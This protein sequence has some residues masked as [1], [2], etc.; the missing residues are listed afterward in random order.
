MT[1]I[2]I[3]LLIMI[4]TNN[5]NRLAEAEAYCAAQPLARTCL[6]RSRLGTSGLGD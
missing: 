5:N 6:G 4:T 3:T 2:I 1:T